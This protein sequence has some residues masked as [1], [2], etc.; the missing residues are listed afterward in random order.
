MAPYHTPKITNEV[1][2]VLSSVINS[3]EFCFSYCFISFVCAWRGEGWGVEASQKI[4]VYCFL[5]Y[6]SW[7]PVSMSES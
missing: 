7:E 5:V 6:V 2:F 1:C 4:Q 3:D